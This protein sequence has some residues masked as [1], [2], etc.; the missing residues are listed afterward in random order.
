M[1][2][3]IG[4]L[5]SLQGSLFLM[6]LLGLFLKKTGIID[7][8]GVRCLTDLCMDVIIPCN[9][10]KSCLVDF[11]TAEMQ[12]CWWILLVSVLMQFVGIILNR[13]LFNRFNEQQKK[14]LQYCTIV[15]NGAF[16][17]NPVAEGIYGNIGLLYSSIFLIP[18]RMVIWSVGTS[19][20]VSGETTDRKKVI[21]NVLTHPCLVAV[22]I[23]LLIMVTKIQLPAFM[24]LTIKSIGNC[25]SAVTMMIVGTILADVKFSTIINKSTLFISLLRLVL[26]PLVAFG[27]STV[28]GLE[29]AA[30]GV[31]VIMVGMPAGATA[32]IFAA[33][34][35]SDAPFATKCV[36]LSTLLSMITIPIWCYLIG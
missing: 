35:N 29:H 32:A 23:G 17:G 22:Y 20:F 26:L 19:Y 9:T 18:Q 28:C 25:N 2:V 30:A 21:R 14:V 13:F 16:L 1:R 5:F 6:I 34:Y 4:Q 31:C 11:D 33:R 36:V 7:D 24:T 27:L 10:I 15:S 12:A 8:N 3:D